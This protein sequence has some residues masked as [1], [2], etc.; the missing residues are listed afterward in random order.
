MRRRAETLHR[1]SDLSGRVEIDAIA[2]C[3]PIIAQA[4]IKNVVDR[5]R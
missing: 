4:T 3:H 5:Y 1:F 2:Q